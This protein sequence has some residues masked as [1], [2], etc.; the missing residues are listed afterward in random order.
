MELLI[1]NKRHN[2]SVRGYPALISAIQIDNVKLVLGQFAQITYV[3]LRSLTFRK[4]W[5]HLKEVDDAF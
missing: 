2:L 5:A 4:L 1:R 3:H